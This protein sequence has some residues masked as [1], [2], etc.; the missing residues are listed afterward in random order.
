MGNRPLGLRSN[1]WARRQPEQRKISSGRRTKLGLS[2]TIPRTDPWAGCI[3]QNRIPARAATTSTRRHAPSA[4]LVSIIP[5]GRDFD[6]V[7]VNLLD[8]SSGVAPAALIRCLR[9]QVRPRP[10]RDRSSVPEPAHLGRHRRRLGDW[11]STGSAADGRCN[12]A[13]RTKAFRKYFLGL[14]ERLICA[15]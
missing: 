8:L 13:S 15:T 2:V 9:P 12:P 11:Q 7:S 1:Q 6:R 3:R 14:L 4:A 5:I 10:A